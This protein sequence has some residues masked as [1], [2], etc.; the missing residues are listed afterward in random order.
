MLFGRKCA[1]FYSHQLINTGLDPLVL[2]QQ[3]LSL[4]PPDVIPLN[5]INLFGQIHPFVLRFGHALLTVE[6]ADEPRV[7]GDAGGDGSEDVPHLIDRYL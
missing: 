1:Q 5:V 4:R 3:T 6:L 2:V 7:R